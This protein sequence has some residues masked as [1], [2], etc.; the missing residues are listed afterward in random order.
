M[1]LVGGADYAI[2][3]YNLAVVDESSVYPELCRFEGHA[4]RVE[5]ISVAENGQVCHYTNIF[6][7]GGSILFP[8]PQS[9]LVLQ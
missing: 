1:L 8:P 7:E 2:K 3:A 9:D 5:T 4:G 6:G